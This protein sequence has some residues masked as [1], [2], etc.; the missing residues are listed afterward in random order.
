LL[1]NGPGAF[2]V[3]TSTRYVHILS[4]SP[5]YQ[6]LQNCILTQPPFH[7]ITCFSQWTPD[8][9]EP[10]SWKGYYMKN[11]IVPTDY[12]SIHAALAIVANGSKK[13]PRQSGNVRVLVRPGRY[14][15]PEAVT[16]H[17]TR[18]TTRITLEAMSLPETFTPGDTSRAFFYRNDKRVTLVSKTRLRNEPLFRVLRGELVLKNLCLEHMAMGVD[19][20]RGNAAIHVQPSIG[21]STLRPSAPVAK[22]AAVLESVEIVSESG[23]GILAID[24]AHVHI[25]GSYIHDCAATGVYVGGHGTRVVLETVDVT[26]NGTGNQHFGGIARGQSGMCIDQGVVSL[27]DCNVSHN[28]ASGISIIS[29][30]LTELTLT[31]TDVLTNGYKQIHVHVGSLDRVVINPDCKLAVTGLSSPRSTILV[32]ERADIE[33]EADLT[34]F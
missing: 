32:A 23:R 29:P 14:S 34:G 4:L 7:F 24:G 22:A 15:M 3:K 13:K 8:Q 30:D 11:P 2:S 1:R 12:P 18:R 28:V 17:A 20:W 26:E 16:I 19:I 33:S 25:K 31:K 27:T 10:V 9:P 21:E 5:T 6:A